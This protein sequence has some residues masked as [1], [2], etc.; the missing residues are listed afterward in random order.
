MIIR[1]ATRKDSDVLTEIS[2]LA[3]NYW[4]YPAQYF[5]IWRDELTITAEY[6]EK[7]NVQVIE[8]DDRVVGYY[9]VVKIEKD[10]KVEGFTLEKGVWLEHLF[11]LPEFIGKGY[12][13]RLMQHL[14]QNSQKNQWQELKILADPH[15]TGFYRKLGARYIQEVPSNIPGRTVSYLEWITGSRAGVVE[16]LLRLKS[17]EK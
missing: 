12:G 15:S 3:K 8:D 1:P 16:C 13:K 11:I 17:G 6:I 4:N 10:L 9:S 2:F 7:N 14:L 5:E